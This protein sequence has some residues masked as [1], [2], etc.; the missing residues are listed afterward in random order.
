MRTRE[1]TAGGGISR[2]QIYSTSLA[3]PVSKGPSLDGAD[4][5]VASDN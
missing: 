2:H 3:S 5:G 4:S 1:E